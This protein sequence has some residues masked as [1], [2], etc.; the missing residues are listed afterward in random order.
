MH[1][2]LSGFPTLCF[3]AGGLLDVFSPNLAMKRK[4]S[5]ESALTRAL[6]SGTTRAEVLDSYDNMAYAPAFAKPYISD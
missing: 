6:A 4:T 1:V 5:P 3:D 2:K